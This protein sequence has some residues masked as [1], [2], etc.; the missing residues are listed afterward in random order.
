MLLD[1]S[2]LMLVKNVN[3]TYCELLARNA[4]H[5]LVA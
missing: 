5:E 3:I 4:E 1:D 2:E